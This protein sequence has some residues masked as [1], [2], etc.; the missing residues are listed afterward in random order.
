MSLQYDYRWLDGDR[1]ESPIGAEGGSI[2]YHKDWGIINIQGRKA[3]TVIKRL[4]EATERLMDGK[5]LENLGELDIDTLI[6]LQKLME[7]I[8][9]AEDYKKK[10][11]RF[12]SHCTAVIR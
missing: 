10:G 12:Y 5:S 9:Q 1:E 2:P 3:K 11:Y 6:L 7:V 8:D 4:R